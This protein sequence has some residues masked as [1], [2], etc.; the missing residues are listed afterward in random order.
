MNINTCLIC[1]DVVNEY[2]SCSSLKCRNIICNDCAETYITYSAEKNLIAKCPG[3]K[4]EC[5]YLISSILKLDQN[6]IN[7]Y[8]KSC[9]DYLMNKSRKIIEDDSVYNQIIY[10]IKEDRIKFI[11][12]NVPK[13]ISL[14][15]DIALKPK[16]NKIDKKNKLLNNVI[17]SKKFCMISYCNGKLNDD[18]ECIKCETKFCKTCERILSDNH[19]CKIED[20]ESVSFINKLVKCPKCRLPVQKNDGCNAITC[21]VCF[22]NFDYI[23]GEVCDAGNHNKSILVNISE[24]NILSD[25]YNEYYNKYVIDKLKKIESKKPKVSDIGPINNIVKKIYE[26]Y[27]VD[28]EF[29]E[30]EKILT[31]LAF[32]F[33]KYINNKIRYS[34][35]IKLYS[36]IEDLHAGDGLTCVELNDILKVI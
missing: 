2:I 23:S 5:F 13:A 16:L 26:E 25:E 28:I 35:Y 7:I 17:K 6:I 33:E 1:Y 12:D 29:Q 8:K 20:I 30:N 34:R 32:K 4:C 11:R 36:S 3:D 31:D 10:K 15:I 27:G 24:Y 9:Y 18:L 21:A 22:T 19:I 14:I